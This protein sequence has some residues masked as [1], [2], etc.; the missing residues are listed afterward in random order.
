[1]DYADFFASLALMFR[2]GQAWM[3]VSRRRVAS[4]YPRRIKNKQK[5]SA[6]TPALDIAVGPIGTLGGVLIG[7]VRSE[8]PA[9]CQSASR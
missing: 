5:A 8:L 4:G 9:G 1:M 3:R 7:H 2:W 6:Q